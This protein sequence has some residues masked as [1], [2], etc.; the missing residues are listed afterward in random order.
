M[1]KQTLVTQ[2]LAL[3]ALLILATTL[4]GMLA[5]RLTLIGDEPDVEQ[6]LIIVTGIF[7]AVLVN[8]I[9]LRRRFASL[10]RLINLME[11][12]DLSR[13]GLRADVTSADTSDV[14][15]LCRAFNRMLA[16]V[17]DERARTGSAVLSGQEQ[18]RARLA[19]DLHDECNQ[20]LTGILLRLEALR[21]RTEPDLSAE[22]ATIKDLTA[23]AMEELL[24][25]ARELRPT[26]LDDHGLRVALQA[27]TERFATVTGLITQLKIDSDTTGT[28]ETLS[29]QEQ[30]VVYRITQEA[31]SNA[32]RHADATTVEVHL[33]TTASGAISVTIR[34]DGAGITTDPKDGLG[35]V[36]M[37]ERARLVSGTLTVARAGSGG[38]EVR[39]ELADPVPGVRVA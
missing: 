13:P 21:Q 30:I 5:A 15:R 34:D 6:A 26:V 33:S 20:A 38:T 17:E 24:H 4:A 8:G 18:E 25:L 22:L 7:A 14:V 9:L 29:E 37:H 1:R 28:L 35:L 11:D 12:V 32:F 23:Q 36:G 39:L 31:L 16:R 3:N 2:I 10:D 19:R 27:Q